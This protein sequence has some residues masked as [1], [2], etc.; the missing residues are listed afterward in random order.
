MA[1]EPGKALALK[2]KCFLGQYGAAM[3]RLSEGDVP[4]WLV[5]EFLGKDAESAIGLRATR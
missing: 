5:R 3:H 1:G 4:V 2:E